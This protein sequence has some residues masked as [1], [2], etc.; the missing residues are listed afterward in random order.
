MLSD[1]F[2][3]GISPSEIGRRSFVYRDDL[4]TPASS[5]GSGRDLDR[6]WTRPKQQQG[7][8]R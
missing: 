6:R 7:D 4:Q 8:Q 2:A 5:L 3:I 1:P